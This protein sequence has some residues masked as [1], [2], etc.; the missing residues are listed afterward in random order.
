MEMEEMNWT[1]EGIGPIHND[2]LD[3]PMDCRSLSHCDFICQ[4]HY[5]TR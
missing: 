4:L 5:S 2:E 3:P 1:V